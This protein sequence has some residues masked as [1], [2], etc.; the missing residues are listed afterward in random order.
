MAKQVLLVGKDRNG[1]IRPV[2]IDHRGMVHQSFDYRGSV[3]TGHAQIATNTADNETTV[4][5]ADADNFLELLQITGSNASDVAVTIFIRDGVGTGDHD[6]VI[7]IP[8]NDT[9]VVSY[10]IPLPQDEKGTVWTADFDEVDIT[11]TVVTITM[12]AYRNN[13][14]ASAPDAN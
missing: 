9:K 1:D 6:E 3:A 4:L 13:E 12:L 2:L 7:T 11:N 14:A 10:P 5:A 8:P